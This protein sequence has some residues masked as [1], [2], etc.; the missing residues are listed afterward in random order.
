MAVLMI[1]CYACYTQTPNATAR[2]FLCCGNT[3]QWVQHSSEL[4]C[5]VNLI[6]QPVDASAYQKRDCPIHLLSAPFGVSMKEV[7]EHL[8]HDANSSGVDAS[9]SLILISHQHELI[10]RTKIKCGMLLS[11]W[12]SSRSVHA[13]VGSQHCR[14]A[15]VYKQQLLCQGC[16][17]ASAQRL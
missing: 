13:G 1:A 4:S 11:H 9:G 14:R 12:Q 15:A 17:L 5:V 3:S 16:F 6:M 2:C 10:R 7:S 8:G